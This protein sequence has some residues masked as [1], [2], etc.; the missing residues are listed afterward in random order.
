MTAPYQRRRDPQPV[1]QGW[2]IAVAAIGG[3]LLGL[4]LAALAGLGLASA[5]FGSGWVWP[6]GTDTIGHVIGGVLTGQPGRG[7]PPTQIQL[8]AARGAVYGCIA[9][10]ELVVI[11]LAVTVGVLV[12]RYRRPNDA[13]SGMATRSEA[14]Q[15]LGISK[16]RG[17]KEI[18]RPD[19]YGRDATSTKKAAS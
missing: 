18:I 14:E 8:V 4:G 11:V 9:G 19:L 6:H 2:E 10:S 3:A 12:S 15:V 7:L 1:S 5:V 16:L 13:R 17:A